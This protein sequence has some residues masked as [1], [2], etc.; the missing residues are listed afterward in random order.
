MSEEQTRLQPSDDPFGDEFEECGFSEDA[1]AY[2]LGELQGENKTRFEQHRADCWACQQSQDLLPVDFDPD[3][4][5]SEE[6][7]ARW[8]AFKGAMDRTVAGDIVPDEERLRLL[9]MWRESL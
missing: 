6:A 4:P 5:M 1:V 9:R 2:C 3:P 7:K 8:K